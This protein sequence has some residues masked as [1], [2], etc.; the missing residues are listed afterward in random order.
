MFKSKTETSLIAA[1]HGQLT[2]YFFLNFGAI[3]FPFLFYYM[4]I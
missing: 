4:S 2:T 1:L 3:H